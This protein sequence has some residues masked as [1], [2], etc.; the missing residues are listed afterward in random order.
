MDDR[1]R[2]SDADRDRVTARLRDHF[3]AGRLTSDELDQRISAALN[4][5][6]FG[7]LR[8]IMT[9]LPEPAPALPRA[10][11]RPWRAAPPW[12]VRHHGPRAAPLILLALLLAVVIP[13]GG[14]LLFAF[15]KVILVFWLVACLAG[16][17]FASR[18]H[19]RMRRARRSG[20]AQQGQDYPRW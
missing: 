4:A 9:D 5:K 20:Y 7:D 2:V 1:I 17:L 13:G 6:T 3:A 11:Q 14:W 8:H 15:F 19:R 16:I 18:F 10:E 12:L